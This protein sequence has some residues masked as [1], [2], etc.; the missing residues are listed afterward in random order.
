MSTFQKISQFIARKLNF[1]TGNWITLVGLFLAMYGIELFHADLGLHGE[2]GA[3]ALLTLS[4]LTDWWDGLVSKY[5]Q[6]HEGGG[7]E[8]G[9]SLE[10]ELKMSFVER[11]NHRGTTHLGKKL[12]PLVDKVRFIGLLWVVGEGFIDE[13][14]VWA[15]TFMAA[16]LVIV[17]PIKRLLMLG[18]A[19]SNWFGRRK[20]YFEVLVIAML[21]FSTRP[22]LSD[23]T[24]L[25]SHHIF[26]QILSISLILAL[27]FSFLSFGWH[28][29][30][31]MIEAK[32]RKEGFHVP[33]EDYEGKPSALGYLLMTIIVLTVICGGPILFVT[34]LLG[35][36]GIMP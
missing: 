10:D 8:H 33:G 24:S 17:R 15:L 30:G 20:V 22:L 11:M 35:E 29:F 3:V 32:L 26:D 23:S 1:T 18:D 16:L 6:V 12:D 4:F 31:Q 25:L 5:Q 36:I 21:V 19:S 13:S 34:K 7:L 28:L 9:I 2:W 27:A 14:M